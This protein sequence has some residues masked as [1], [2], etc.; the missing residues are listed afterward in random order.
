MA[1]VNDTI[2]LP[3][4]ECSRPVRLP[5]GPVRQASR[6]GKSYPVFCSRICNGKY[7]AKVSQSVK[8][9]WEK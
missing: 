6:K 4:W 3:C 5:S 2:V 7:I 8:D 1:A 9:D